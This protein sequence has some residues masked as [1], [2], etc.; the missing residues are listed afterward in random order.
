[1]PFQDEMFGQ[2]PS[3]MDDQE[4]ERRRQER[5][6]Q[7][8][9][10]TFLQQ[11]Q[12]QQQPQQLQAPQAP[13]PPPPPSALMQFQDSQFTKADELQLMKYR[14]GAA[15]IQD[16]L[17][18]H[19]ISEFEAEQLMQQ[20]LPTMT[21]LEKRQ[22]ATQAKA[23]EQEKAKAMDQLALQW[24]VQQKHG[25][26]EADSFPTRMRTLVNKVTGAAK[27]YVPTSLGK[28]EPVD[29]GDEQI[30]PGP[31]SLATLGA[32]IGAQ[33]P[34]GA[35]LPAGSE[36]LPAS[37]GGPA[38]PMP[39]EQFGEQV[40]ATYSG[41]KSDALP[42]I[43]NALGQNIDQRL[44]D[45]G[46]IPDPR[47]SA[48]KEDLDHISPEAGKQFYKN[49]VAMVPALPAN[50]NEHQRL[51][52]QAQVDEIVRQQAGHHLFLKRHK[53]TE[54]AARKAHDYEREASV[55][56]AVEIHKQ[57]QQLDL[58]QL[59]AKAGINQELGKGVRGSIT[60]EDLSKII[61]HYD[62][63]VNHDRAAAQKRIEA[64]GNPE[65]G[66][67]KATNT[68]EDKLPISLLP[69]NHTITRDKLVETH[70]DA[71]DAARGFKKGA[72]KGD[73]DIP[74]P[75][76]VGGGKGG[77][78][79]GVNPKAVQAL[80][81]HLGQISGIQ[82]VDPRPL[83]PEEEKTPSNVGYEKV[84]ALNQKLGSYIQHHRD[85]DVFGGELVKILSNDLY[86]SLS[87][88]LNEK[89]PLTRLEKYQWR[90]ALEKLKGKQSDIAGVREI[91]ASLSLE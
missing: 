85:K 17:A 44:I 10:N 61:T 40:R 75:A 73:K 1:M 13:T 51:A 15:T 6:M 28:W 55:K 12:A 59:K 71:L 57:K 7:E 11:A 25:D 32:G 63:Q 22:Q 36:A 9:N 86:P 3:F 82:N 18:N 27:D 23:Q 24:S 67:T 64:T 78:P 49:A 30:P 2:Y 62:T 54:E 41:N 68:G 38:E 83:T 43:R 16:Q 72:G 69:I 53:A 47:K 26:L 77:P 76:D 66:S 80:N 74:P 91:A 8:Q 31:G 52:W 84:Q 58:D 81:E 50:A 4:E 29:Y 56:T 20:V 90:R 35:P 33:M 65:P 48:V 60:D 79:P 70:L 19:E 87:N 89:R 37:Q 21:A 45:S 14:A 39:L 5:D 46:E 34:A 42:Q 88:A